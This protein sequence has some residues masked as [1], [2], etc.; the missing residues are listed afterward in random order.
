M[1][2]LAL[3]LVIVTLALTGCAHQYVMRLNNGHEITTAS[4]PKLKDGIYHFKDARGQEHT[5]GQA[6]VMQV[7]PASMATAER[8]PMKPISTGSAAPKKRHWYLLWL[9]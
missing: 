9:A 5:V 2:K 4:K 7:E 6:R 3:P 8:K 1:K